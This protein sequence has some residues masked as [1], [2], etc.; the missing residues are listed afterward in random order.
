VF[1]DAGEI[2]VRPSSSTTPPAT[3]R[4]RRGSHLLSTA[5]F[6][7]AIVLAAIAIWMYI[8]QRNNAEH[9]LPP[10]TAQ[11][12]FNNLASVV[13]AL[14]TAGLKPDYGRNTAN[15]AQL[16]QPGQTVTLASKPVLYVFIY[17]DPATREQDAKHLDPATLTLTRLSGTAIPISGRARVYQGSNVIAVYT[18]GDDATG[19]KVQQAIERLP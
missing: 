10:P 17:P 3:A 9:E 13:G 2:Q 16:T 18:G 11:A 6:V 19:A 8:D 12:G 4:S 14:K 5:L 7:A 15:T 1:L